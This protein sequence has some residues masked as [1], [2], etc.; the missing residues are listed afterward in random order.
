M[1][2]KECLVNPDSPTNIPLDAGLEISTD[3]LKRLTPE[4][5]EIDKRNKYSGKRLIRSTYLCVTAPVV[6]GTLACVVGTYS[7]SLLVGSLAAFSVFIGPISAGVISLRD[8]RET[9]KLKKK[10][11]GSI[12]DCLSDQTTRE[13]VNFSLPEPNRLLDVWNP[14]RRT[15]EETLARRLAAYRSLSGNQPGLDVLLVSPF[16]LFEQGGIVGR[17]RIMQTGI[18]K[19]ISLTASMPLFAM[20]ALNLLYQKEASKGSVQR[21]CIGSPNIEINQRKMIMS[22]PETFR[23]HLVEAKLICNETGELREWYDGVLSFLDKTSSLASK[24]KLKIN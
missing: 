24:D 6:G 12:L 17:E 11:D 15:S 21:A 16:V 4:F 19:L 5:L 8:L 10:I 7:G 14:I 22:N 18:Q 2:Q 20:S 3:L 9:K 13:G 1:Q 23:K